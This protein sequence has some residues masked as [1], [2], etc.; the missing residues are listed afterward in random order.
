MLPALTG[1]QAAALLHWAASGAADNNYIDALIADML[2]KVRE[3]KTKFHE[4][5]KIGEHGWNDARRL[6]LSWLDPERPTFEDLWRLSAGY[7]A[8]EFA[9]QLG[10]ADVCRRRGVADSL[11]VRSV[12]VTVG[13]GVSLAYS[14]IVKGRRYQQNDAYDLW[15]AVSAST[16]DIFVTFDADLKEA[17]DRVPV[18]GFSVL[19]SLR[20]L[21]GP[22]R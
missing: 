16:A 8:I 6:V 9:K 21:L 3:A 18:R 4:P 19:S 1:V 15:H 17:L 22:S 11:E 14:A 7:W 20:E 2:A 10:L 12:K 5:M 13:A